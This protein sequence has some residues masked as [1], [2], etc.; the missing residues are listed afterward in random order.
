MLIAYLD[1]GHKGL[2]PKLS[3]PGYSKADHQE[4]R[5]LQR[6]VDIVV[7]DNEKQK[8]AQKRLTEQL[9]KEKKE[10]EFF[11]GLANDHQQQ[12]LD[13]EKV[14]DE[15]GVAPTA[16]EELSDRAVAK[17]ERHLTAQF[18]ERQRAAGV[19]TGDDKFAKSVQIKVESE[20]GGSGFSL[21]QVRC[22]DWPNSAC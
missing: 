13:L 6:T 18:K 22:G 20:A 14:M 16:K 21:E 15:L 3:K 17:Y 2:Y 19:L 7:R 8:E 5:I 9:A 10:V 11:R 1:F 4:K 12:V